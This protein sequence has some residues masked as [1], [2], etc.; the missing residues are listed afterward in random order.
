MKTHFL[1]TVLIVWK[2]T[3]A[4]Y[5]YCLYLFHL[6]LKMLLY[7][8][9]DM[10]QQKHYLFLTRIKE[11]TLNYRLRWERNLTAL[12]ICLLLSSFSSVYH[13]VCVWP[14]ALKLGCLINLWHAL[15]CYTGSLVDEIHFIIISS[16]LCIG[17]R[18]MVLAFTKWS[19]ILA[20]CSRFHS[21]LH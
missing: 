20:Q 11:N 2:D 17:I 7:I 18:S 16:Y 15:S 14:T 3:I 8:L 10:E 19:L 4:M 5:I 6:I 12:Y 21:K 1:W 9:R 13:S